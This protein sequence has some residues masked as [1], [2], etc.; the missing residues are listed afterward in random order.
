[1]EEHG[2]AVGV[3]K[4]ALTQRPIDVVCGNEIGEN[5]LLNVSSCSPKRLGFEVFRGVSIDRKSCGK[6]PEELEN[7]VNANVGYDSPG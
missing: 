4:A 2:K 3:G 1:M 7:G 6:K 5:L